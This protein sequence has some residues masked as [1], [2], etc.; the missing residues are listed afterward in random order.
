MLHCVERAT[1][2]GTMVPAN[3]DQFLEQQRQR[4]QAMHQT[5]QHR[6][7]AQRQGTYVYLDGRWLSNFCSNDYLGF[8]Q[9][10]AMIGSVC[11]ATQAFG[12][13]AGA[14]HLICGHFTLHDRAERAFADWLEYPKA[15]L[16]SNGFLANLAVHQAWLSGRSSVSVQDRLNHASLID[17]ARL[18][19]CQLRRYPHRDIHGA[20]RQLLA[21]SGAMTVLATD[22]VFSMDGDLAP[23]RALSQVS[24]AQDALLFVDDAHG[25][26]VMGPNGRGSAAHAGLGYSQVPAQ[27]ITLGKAF[28]GHGALV[29]GEA[30]LID[31]LAETARPHLYTTALP[32]A[33]AAAA[34]TAL[35]L[36][37]DGEPRRAHLRA[38]ISTFRQHALRHGLTLLP[39]QT[40]IQPLL[41][42]QET[43]AI[44][45]AKA[46]E[47][48][49]FWVS[50]IRPPTVPSGTARL[51][52]TLTALHSLEQVRLFVEALAKI[53]D[54]LAIQ[55]RSPSQT[56]I[57]TQSCE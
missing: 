14:S 2:S 51:R 52:I 54:Q 36:V 17:G 19:G 16:F 47:Q 27:L 40:P 18:A 21:A 22:G 11:E 3:I 5:R 56:P 50:A 42:G 53:R 49:G 30:S 4:R 7:I 41:C 46:L 23:L 8:A 15:V 39:S 55:P 38:V 25:A 12:V 33:L 32:P 34:L 37:H 24:Q 28:G 6:P 20:Q 57:A 1:E 29:V 31:H 26:G 48:A 13:G 45:F 35:Q 44:A 9:H 10:P 43:D